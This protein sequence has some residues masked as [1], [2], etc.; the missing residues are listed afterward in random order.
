MHDSFSL[1]LPGDDPA[2]V[3]DQ[4]ERWIAAAQADPVAFEPLYLLYRARIYH[5]L[6]TRLANE[7][8]AADLTQQVFL[9]ALA[10][11]PRYRP[12]GTPF[13]VWLFRIARNTAINLSSRHPGCVSWDA[14]PETFCPV[15]DAEQDPEA[16][17]LRQEAI[18]H[19]KALLASLDPDK[20]ELLALR[21]AGG[22]NSSQISTLVG[23]KPEAVKKQIN[24]LLQSF[25]ERYQHEYL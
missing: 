24:R 1:S 3:L 25:K 19:L 13:V 4:E 2:L 10:A 22:L 5:Y 14:L 18:G 6:R 7:E 16:L 21:F 9:Q 17:V 23:K 11:L 15:E 20:R 12:S 8:D